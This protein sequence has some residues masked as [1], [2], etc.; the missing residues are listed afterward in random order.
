MTEDEARFPPQDAISTGLRGRCPRCGEGHLFDGL[1]KVKPSCS[2]CGLDFS[3]ADAGDGP[4]V[5]VMLILGFVI[6]GFALWL[7]FT[8]HPPVWLHFLV[9]APFAII[10]S[11][12]SLRWLK[13]VLISLQYRHSAQEGRI[14]RG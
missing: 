2:A 10:V 7:E 5:F 14:D 8:F 12:A 4:A 9:T 3:F 6:V 13:G 11:L 1:L